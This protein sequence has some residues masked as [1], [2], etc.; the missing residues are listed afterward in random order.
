MNI[1]LTTN[2][3]TGQIYVWMSS[4]NLE[5][6]YLGDGVNSKDATTFMRPY[7]PFQFA[8]KK[9]GT[10]AFK[11]IT[12]YKYNEES[13][14]REKFE[15]IVNEQFI[16]NPY[17]YNLSKTVEDYDVYQFDENKQLKSKW[18]AE[19]V[20]NFF[21][22]S[23]YALERAVK[24]GYKL[25]GYY[26]ST[27]DT[28]PKELKQTNDKFIYQYTKEG[29]CIAV[30]DSLDDIS[31]DIYKALKYQLLVNNKYYY[32]ERLFDIFKPKPRTQ[33]KG[34]KYYLYTITGEF[35]K[36][37]AN[38]KEL[39]KFINLTSSKLLQKVVTEL[40]GKYKEFFISTEYMGKKIPAQ[41]VKRVNVFDTDGKLLETCDS[42]REAARKYNTHLSSVNKV[43]HGVA[44]TAGGYVFKYVQ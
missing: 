34:T 5:D 12:L 10:D 22:G 24:K 26:W 8:V 19:D 38:G 14:A 42:E 11:R 17:T 18:K 40:N 35:I 41:N 4:K 44:H 21:N 36:E 20:V 28:P 29:K 3:K 31:E 27:T 15:Q 6:N 7:T 9:Y 25:Y 30:Y 43:L 37:F 32:S 2:T 13:E 33:I 23:P 16:S 1:Y 39:M